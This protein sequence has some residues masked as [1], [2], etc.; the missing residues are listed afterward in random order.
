[1]S[2]WAIGLPNK[3]KLFVGWWGDVSR[4][5]DV[6]RVTV[7]DIGQANIDYVFKCMYGTPPTNLWL[8]I[9]EIEV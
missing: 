3:N 4:N 5:D 6:S 2:H 8:D 1:M 9:Y 7:N